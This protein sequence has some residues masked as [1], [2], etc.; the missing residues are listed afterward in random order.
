MTPQTFSIGS[1]A[2][3]AA[4]NDGLRRLAP[5]MFDDHAGALL[6]PVTDSVRINISAFFAP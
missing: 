6:G 4:M 2:A 5:Q 1:D 3:R